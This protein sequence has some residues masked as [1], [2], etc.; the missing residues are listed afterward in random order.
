MH[1]R[2]HVDTSKLLVHI[3]HVRFRCPVERD[4]PSHD[5]KV[6]EQGKQV[7][8]EG[9]QMHICLANG[10]QGVGFTLSGREGTLGVKEMSWIVEMV[11]QVCTFAN[12]YTI[13]TRTVTVCLM[14]TSGRITCQ[15]GIS[16]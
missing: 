3:P 12:T 4:C 8:R 10:R 13:D 2:D 6:R 1:T 9:R 15:H 7:D 16:C 11:S 5:P 14:S